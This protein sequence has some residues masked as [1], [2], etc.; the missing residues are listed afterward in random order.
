MNRLIA[1]GLATALLG[2]PALARL[3]GTDRATFVKEDIETCVSMQKFSLPR[4][5]IP[6]AQYRQ[7]CECRAEYLAQH[8][9]PQQLKNWRE[10]TI[11]PPSV[12][13][14]DTA[15]EKKVFGKV[16]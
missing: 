7:F 15:C 4:R 5:N 11:A 8:T 1:I 3:T 10:K 14:T 2:T 16:L 12:P 13:D 6:A 9:T